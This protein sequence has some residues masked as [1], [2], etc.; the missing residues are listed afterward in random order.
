MY[1]SS[2]A[3]YGNLPL[4]DENS[5]KYEILSPY[6]LDKLTQEYYAKLFYDTYKIPSI[7]LRFFNVYGPK[8][9]PF[10]PYSGV[11]SVFIDRFLKKLPVQI[12]GGYQTRDFVYVKDVSKSL[13][14]S[15]ELL[16]LDNICDFINIGTGISIS[17]DSLFN[18]L[19]K[20]SGYIPEKIYK[21]LPEG[22]PEKSSGTYNKMKEILNIDVN[23][24][25]VFET[26]LKNTYEYFKDKINEKI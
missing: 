8:Q 21:S 25:I 11:I 20:I 3:I 2:S 14:K 19:S 6:A 26:G 18:T 7:G 23:K 13:M 16:H 10:N 17:I 15:M 12:N 9:D 4:G 5:K 1:A 24:F 22:D